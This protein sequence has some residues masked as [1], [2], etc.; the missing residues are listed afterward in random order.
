MTTGE[1][2][3]LAT[4]ATAGTARF[5]DRLAD[6]LTGRLV[7]RGRI[8]LP[9]RPPIDV[10][11]GRYTVHESDG[12]VVGETLSGVVVEGEGCVPRM[13]SVVVR[14]GGLRVDSDTGWP[15]WIVSDPGL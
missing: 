9:D 1:N 3:S 13:T 7:A 4:T 12:L 6:L 5:T 15:G 14:P 8:V 10:R 11:D 2:T